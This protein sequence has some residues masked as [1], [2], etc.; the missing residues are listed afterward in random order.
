MLLL[1]YSEAIFL[2]F[3]ELYELCSFLHISQNLYRCIFICCILQK[4]D[5]EFENEI[6]GAKHA[7]TY[8]NAEIK[9]NF[10]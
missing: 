6:A 1:C 3:K 4:N 2:V 8:T 9:A 10:L 5:Q 7:H